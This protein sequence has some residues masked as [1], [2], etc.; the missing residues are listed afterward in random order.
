MYHGLRKGCIVVDQS[1]KM[2]RIVYLMGFGV[3]VMGCVGLVISRVGVGVLFGAGNV[4]G[5]VIC[6]CVGLASNRDHGGYMLC[7]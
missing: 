4:M 6:V 2:L 5:E 1:W 3:G 7:E